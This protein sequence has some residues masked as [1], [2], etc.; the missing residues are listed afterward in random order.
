MELD[1]D[2][3]IVGAGPVG[4]TLAVDLGRRGVKATLVEKLDA[5][6]GYPKME[7]CN[8]RTM[9]I[10]RRLGIAQMVRDA[11]Y[12]ADWPMDNYLVRTMAEEP[13]LRFPFPT[14]AQNRART[15]ATNDGSLPLEPYQ[16]ISQYTLEPLLK[17][18][19]ETLP[20]ISV[21][22]GHGF[23]EFAQEPDAVCATI[24]RSDGE[25][26]TLRTRYLVG[27]DGGASMVRRQL[28]FRMEGE[29]ELLTMHQALFRCDDLWDHVAVPR[30]RHYHRIDEFWTFLIVQDSTKHFTVHSIVDDAEQMKLRFEQVVGSKLDYE[31]L[32]I[33]KWV[34]RL[35]LAT[36]YAEKRV[37]LAGDACHL[38]IPTGGLGM[39]TGVGDAIDISWK[40]AATL[41]GWGGP[42]LLSSYE[43][44]RRQVGGR[45]VR[46][47]GTGNAGRQ[48][49]RAAWQPCIEDET[50]EGEAARA[51]L[52]E[53][54]SVEGKKSSAVVGAELGYRYENSPIIAVEPG[55]PP[56]H[57]TETYVPTAWPG[58]RLP[59]IWL[60]PGLSVHD[61]IKDGYTLLRLATAPQDSARLTREFAALG[62]PFSVLD[63]G[64]D[65]ARTMYQAD[66]LLLRPDLHVVW[67][68][69]ALPEDPGA[70]ARLATGHQPQ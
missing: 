53:L 51:H 25:V 63:I 22:Y 11:G 3:L 64:S 15:A 19:A 5:P 65:A 57:V 41:Q 21:R 35:L 14:V 6:S 1:A 66:Y 47:S 39:N 68:G 30:G 29:P 7:R 46:A 62:A 40:L 55:E 42:G 23:E 70:L 9:E 27:C 8:P 32:H 28:G 44:E 33:G 36:G 67:R 48:V 10:F 24:R 34:Q 52:I 58:A 38:V 56:P 4:L 60:Q 37:F 69:N 50:P 45:N 16:I 43:I 13:L 59:H 2:V 54:A 18:V 26:I 31:T 17:S 20:S 61:C 49:W 12:P